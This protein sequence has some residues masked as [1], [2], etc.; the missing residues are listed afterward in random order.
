MKTQEVAEKIGAI[1]YVRLRRD[2]KE[3]YHDLEGKVMMPQIKS[4]LKMLMDQ[5]LAII[6]EDR[7]GVEKYRLTKI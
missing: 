5:K 1:I 2:S 6:E 7:E 4:A 3:L